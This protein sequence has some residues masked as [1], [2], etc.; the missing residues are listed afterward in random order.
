[1]CGQSNNLGE[2]MGFFLL[3]VCFEVREGAKSVN[4]L[5]YVW[6]IHIYYIV[7]PY[8]WVRGCEVF[9]FFCLEGEKGMEYSPFSHNFL[10]M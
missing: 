6:T 1:M 3:L 10:G 5:N 8:I 2:G 4:M 9:L 7:Q